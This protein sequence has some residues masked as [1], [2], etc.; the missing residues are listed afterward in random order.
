MTAPVWLI[1]E[2]EFRTYVAT[3]SFWIALAFWVYKDARRRMRDPILVLFA[4]VLGLV[5]PFVGAIVYLLFRPSETLADRR[6]STSSTRSG[7]RRL[8]RWS[9]VN[10]NGTAQVSQLAPTKASLIP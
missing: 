4:A 1:A 6:G 3:A 7:P 2:R 8:A 5:P 9:T 10:T